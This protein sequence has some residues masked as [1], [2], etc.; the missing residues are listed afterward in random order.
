MAY[1][2]HVAFLWHMHQPY[3]K[4]ASSGDFSLPWT[5]LHATKD[6]LHMADV[7]ADYPD[8]HATFNFVPSLI[9]QLED[10]S[11]GASTDRALRISLKDELSSSDK[12]F[13]L[14]FFFSANVDRI[15]NR[16][17][18]YR[19][20]LRQRQEAQ[21]DWRRFPDQYWTDLIVWFNLAWFDGG[22]I[23]SDPELKALTEKGS[24]FSHDDIHLVAEKS[25]NVAGPTLTAYRRLAA[26]GQIELSTSPYYH[27][28]LPLLM[29]SASALEATPGL[30]LPATHFAYPEDATEQV[31]RALL[32]HETAF[33]QPP[34]GMWPSEGAVSQAVADMLAHQTDLRWIASDEG[35]LARSLGQP[36]TRDGDG[37]MTNPR[38]LCQP[39]ALSTAERCN[40][41]PPLAIVF[42]DRLIAD[43]IGFVY[44]YM[45]GRAAA[46]DLVERIRRVRHNINDPD[47][48]YLLSII[49][50]GENCWEYYENNGDEFLRHLYE[51]LSAST[52][53]KTV[54]MSEYLEQFPPQTTLPRLAAGSWI[55]ADMLTWI[56]EPAQN[57][58]WER[59]ARTRECLVSRAAN[60]RATSMDVI[61]HAWRELYIAEG[62][63]WFWWYSSRNNPGSDVFDVAFR[64]HLTEVYRS[65]GLP[66]PDWLSTPIYVN[67][68]AQAGRVPTGYVSPALTASAQAS[69]AWA[70]AGF[71]EPNLS[72]ATMQ[73]NDSIL[74]RFYYGYDAK[75]LYLRVES[76]PVAAAGTI[77]VYFSTPRA[78]SNR[79]APLLPG[80]QFDIG[81]GG[82]FSHALRLN[83]PARQALL[84]RA[85]GYETWLDSAAHVDV[86]YDSYVTEVRLPLADLK[87]LPGD[88]LGVI[89]LLGRDGQIEERHPSTGSLRF[90]LVRHKAT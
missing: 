70:N 61:G 33:G 4:D 60:D 46:E 14:A 35:I 68:P 66:A 5:R 40:G 53:L 19:E 83:L 54:T 2:L 80:A 52:D 22:Y 36:I 43:R 6:Y 39:Y 59:L 76:D 38:L 45:N 23:Q 24:G 32:A 13:L 17:P 41:C 82:G 8:I 63:D 7:L 78:R 62:S 73:R 77:A 55:G 88:T 67:R 11:S 37:H 65:L 51:L 47:H 64:G 34:R 26:R 87:L 79:S 29:E 69:F 10:Y 25:R 74:R 86:A 50:D 15:I 48:P 31:R 81:D 27:P 30:P 72:S 44:Q 20:L 49:L 90:R 21:G 84:Q 56:G 85:D 9:E 57:E 16:Y 58:A 42:R 89:V 12:E 71:I 3:Y 28:I 1:P 18:P 75:N